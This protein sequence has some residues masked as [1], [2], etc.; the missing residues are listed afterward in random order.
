MTLKKHTLASEM[1]FP[2]SPAAKIVEKFGGFKEVA[3][4]LGIGVGAVRRWNFP[5]YRGKGGY[6]SCSGHI[7]SKYWKQLIVAGGQRGLDIKPSD[8]IWIN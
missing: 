3:D 1:P 2:E 5:P 4:A 6:N 7:P 8:F